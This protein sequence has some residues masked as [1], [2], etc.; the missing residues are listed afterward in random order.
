MEVKD[1]VMYHFHKTGIYDNIWKVGNTI[2]IDDNFNSSLASGS[3]SDFNTNGLGE[4]ENVSLGNVIQEYLEGEVSKDK[5]NQIISLFKTRE[6]LIIFKREMAL[7]E[8]RKTYF[9][10]LPS[11]KHCIWVTD[12]QGI[13]FWRKNLKPSKNAKFNLILYSVSLN[14]TIFKT[15]EM[16]L[17]GDNLNY[18]DCLKASFDY[19]NPDFSISSESTDEY[20]FQGKVKIIDRIL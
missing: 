15:N 2:T 5:F 10:S 11:R 1:K 6:E 14:G 19:W 18:N 4:Y 8:I 3:I 20:L 12:K 17:P 13:E 7:E 16:F 9:S